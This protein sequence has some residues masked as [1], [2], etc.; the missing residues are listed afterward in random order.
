M[1]LFG[2]S[3]STAPSKPQKKMKKEN[4]QTNLRK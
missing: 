1:D 4:G 2:L 3:F